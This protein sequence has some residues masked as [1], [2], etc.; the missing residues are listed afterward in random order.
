MKYEMPIAVSVS[1]DEILTHWLFFLFVEQGQGQ[2][3]G[4][5]SKS[6][7]EYLQRIS[8]KSFSIGETQE[9]FY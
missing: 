9:L 6:S 8:G 7:S 3:Q 4:L 2:G 5:W 1:Y